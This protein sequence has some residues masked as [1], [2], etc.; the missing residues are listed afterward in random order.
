MVWVTFPADG[1]EPIPRATY[2]EAQADHAVLGGRL[3][4]TADPTH[5]G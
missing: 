5:T 1:S 4:Q 3:V 2:L